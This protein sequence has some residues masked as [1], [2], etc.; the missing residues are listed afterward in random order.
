M[1]DLDRPGIIDFQQ[2]V[3]ADWSIIREGLIDLDD[4]KSVEAGLQEGPEPIQ[5]YFFVLDHPKQGRFLIDTGMGQVFR[6]PADEWPISSIIQSQMNMDTLKIR[7]TTEEWLKNQNRKIQGVFLTHMH[8]DHI[9]G[10]GDIDSAVPF[11]TGPREA[12]ST[13]FLNMFVRGTTDDL[14]EGK[15]LVELRFPAAAQPAEPTTSEQEPLQIIDFFGDGSLFLIHVPGHTP[16][17]MAFLINGKDGIHLV[18]GDTCHT[19]WGWKHNV[20]PGSFTADHEEN[21][22]S[23]N[24]LQKLASRIKTRKIYPGHQNLD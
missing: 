19:A 16:G 17:S 18:L 5:I 20:V 23:L 9:L 6:Q 24:E 22:H 11:Y 15:H 14:L 2:V 12:T 8:M 21:R 4:P 1:S 7:T 10:A 13:S 3:G